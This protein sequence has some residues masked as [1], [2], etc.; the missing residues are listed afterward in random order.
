MPRKKVQFSFPET[1]KYLDKYKLSSFKENKVKGNKIK[2]SK[3]R[4]WNIGV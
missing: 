2:N 1:I 3:V 4:I